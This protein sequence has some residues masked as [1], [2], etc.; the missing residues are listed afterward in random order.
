MYRI[1]I[2]MIEYNNNFKGTEQLLC[3]EKGNILVSFH[4]DGTCAEYKYS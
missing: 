4:L 3:F 2:N 1:F